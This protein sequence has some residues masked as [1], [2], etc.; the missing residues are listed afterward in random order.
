[1]GDRNGLSFMLSFDKTH[2][3][4]GADTEK[5]FQEFQMFVVCD[6]SSF[7]FYRSIL[8]SMFFT[9]GVFF[10]VGFRADPQPSRGAHGHTLI[11][12]QFC[13]GL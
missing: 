12:T 6:A 5:M 8:S 4:Q 2:D 10:R 9:G 13:Y 7:V 11:N 1:M 3:N